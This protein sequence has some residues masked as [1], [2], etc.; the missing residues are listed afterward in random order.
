MNRPSPRGWPNRIAS[1]VV[2]YA[3]RAVLKRLRHPVLYSLAGALRA[4]PTS[5]VRMFAWAL[6]AILGTLSQGWAMS[7]AV[8]DGFLA[9]DA[10]VGFRWMLIPATGMV[11]SAYAARCGLLAA[12]EVVEAYRDH[13]VERVVASALRDATSTTGPVRID[14]VIARLVGQVEVVRMSLAPSLTG[15]LGLGFTVATALIG[16]G[17]VSLRAAG[18]VAP[19]VLI[20]VVLYCSFLP[21]MLDRSRAAVLA[22]EAVSISVQRNLSGLRDLQVTGAT[23]W[24]TADCG[25]LLRT[26]RLIGEQLAL[27]GV[28]RAGVLVFG[29]A[30]PAVL[31]LVFGPHLL[32]RGTTPGEY[33]AAFGYALSVIAPTLGGASGLI[34]GTMLPLWVTMERLVSATSPLGNHDDPAPGPLP[35]GDGPPVAVADLWF[36]YGPY[37]EPVVAGLDLTVGRGEHLAIVGASGIGKS[38]LA[39]LIC[40]V[41]GPG[42]GTVRVQGRDLSALGP[43][44]RARLRVLIPQ[45]AY[46]FTATLG[47]NLR[48]LRPEASE[49]MLDEA[50]AAVGMSALRD[51]LGGYDAQVTPAQLGNGERQLIALTRA[52]LSP[53]P[54][55]VLDE[56]T[57]HLDPAA[58]E[59][60]ERAFAARPGT[61][62]VI[63]HRMSSA[64]RADRIL[65]MDGTTGYLGTDAFLM[66]TCGPYRDLIG[67]WDGGG[68][69][70]AGRPAYW[71][72]GVPD[73]VPVVRRRDAV[74]T[75]YRI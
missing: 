5:T 52:W 68:V 37:A 1:F 17:A 41:L 51:R 20:A 9:G 44:Q 66:A 75:H 53:A 71:A 4:R 43:A 39:G 36:A 34:V 58:E 64:R 24:A 70:D 73:D 54:L 50:V 29:G 46:V 26:Q 21:D 55:A 30:A 56:A 61:L 10:W 18:L 74:P 16:L 60:A 19:P 67:R 59:R 48:Y 62:I 15:V 47:E 32:D 28:W 22:G 12:G 6:I 40:G 31:L 72:L 49:D 11:L 63:A 27:L 8:D 13:L 23:G 2:V 65:L 7:H 38:T 69:H 3:T 25:R 33:A 14:G 45:E 35:A 42:A 57:C